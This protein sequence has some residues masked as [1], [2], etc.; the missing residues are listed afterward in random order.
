MTLRFFK[1]PAFFYF[2]FNRFTFRENVSGKKIFLTF[3]DGPSK[4]ATPWI[5]EVLKRYHAKATFFCVGEN[6]VEQPALYQQILDA[7][8]QTGNHTFNHLNTKDVSIDSY[9]KNVKKCAEVVNS[10]LFRPPYGRIRPRIAKQLKRM[11]YKLVL[12]TVLSYDFDTELSPGF[13]L[14]KI[15]RQTRPGSIVVFH[16]NVKA[17]RN[18][19]IVLPRYIAFMSNKGYSFELIPKRI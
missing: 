18:L 16:D 2:I 17:K 15:V 11:G 14:R 10:R 3:D 19:Q 13:I 1:F 7:G 4:E 9:I 8:H 12:W 5:L 6:V